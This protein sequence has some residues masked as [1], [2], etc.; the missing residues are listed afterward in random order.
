MRRSTFDEEQIGATLR[1]LEAGAATIEGVTNNTCFEDDEHSHRTA[2]AT[3]PTR[4][5][6]HC[7]LAQLPHFGRHPAMIVC[8]SRVCGMTLE[9]ALLVQIELVSRF[10]NPN[11]RGDQR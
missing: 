2:A 6:G 1:A 7:V 4:V 10:G 8:R 9:S 5:R 11:V 3:M